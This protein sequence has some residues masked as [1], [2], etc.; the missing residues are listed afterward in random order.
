V[1]HKTGI[2]ATPIY[3]NLSQNN[4]NDVFSYMDDRRSDKLHSAAITNSTVSDLAAS[5]WRF[6]NRSTSI[7]DIIMDVTEVI[8]Y[9][10]EYSIYTSACNNST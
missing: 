8:K 10:F 5:L 4:F 6:I 3:A 2:S 1:N 9:I 7:T